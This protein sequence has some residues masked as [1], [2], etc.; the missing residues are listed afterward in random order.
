MV[1]SNSLRSYVNLMMVDFKRPYHSTSIKYLMDLQEPWELL[2]QHCGRWPSTMDF[3][4][5][6]FC[7]LSATSLIV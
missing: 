2:S 3:S 7:T 5:G 1:F 4:E 6:S